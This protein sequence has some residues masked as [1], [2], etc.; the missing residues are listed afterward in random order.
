MPRFINP[1]IDWSCFFSF[2]LLFMPA[3]KNVIQQAMKTQSSVDWLRGF[4]GGILILETE[5]SLLAAVSFFK[6]SD[7]KA[8][9]SDRPVA[10]AELTESAAG[11]D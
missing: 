10:L 6:V 9:E 3:K 5:V 1:R 7:N 11:A 4:T 8:T 2:I